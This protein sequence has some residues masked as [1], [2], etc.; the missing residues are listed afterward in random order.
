MRDHSDIIIRPTQPT[1]DWR[2]YRRWPSDDTLYKTQLG[3][4]RDKRN[5]VTARALCETL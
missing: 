3:L 2:K 5:T 4:S 1:A